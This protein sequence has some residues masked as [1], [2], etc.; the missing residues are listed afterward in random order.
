M[1]AWFV[2][3]AVTLAVEAAVIAALA[4]AG[5]RRRAA[6]TSLCLNLFTHPLANLAY[7]GTL[8]S[9]VAV[10]SAVIAVEAL[11]Y[12]TLERPGLRRALHWSLLAN[13]VTMALS[14]LY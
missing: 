8:L 12:A 10:E 4:H 2:A 11:L 13:G 1:I 7:T 5:K 3:L 14:A 9:F 6:G